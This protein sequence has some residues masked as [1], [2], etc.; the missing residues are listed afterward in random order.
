[1]QIV[2]KIDQKKFKFNFFE[3][4]IKIPIII[5]FFPERFSKAIKI[6]MIILFNIVNQNKK[7][8]LELFIQCKVM[9]IISLLLQS[10]QEIKKL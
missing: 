2:K 7:K 4:K 10:E 6:K 1:M 9:L 5:P 3:E 8:N